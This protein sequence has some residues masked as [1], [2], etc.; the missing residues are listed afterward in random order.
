MTTDEYIAFA[1]ER[2]RSRWGIA[3]ALITLYVAI[4]QPWWWLIVVA[5]GAV[6]SYYL[7][8]AFTAFYLEWKLAD[9]GVSEADQHAAV[10]RLCELADEGVTD[11]EEVEQLRRVAGISSGIV[12]TLS[13]EVVGRYLDNPIFAWIELKSGDKVDRYAF[14]TV[15]PTDGAGN[16]VINL[17]DPECAQLNG[18]NYR[19]VKE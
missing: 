18:I 19:L 10:A 9:T 7:L 15:A 8:L 13:E 2:N 1:V 16:F 4:F 11:G 12:A 3:M 6:V 5:G 14:D 17:N